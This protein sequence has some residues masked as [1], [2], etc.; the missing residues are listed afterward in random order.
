[1]NLSATKQSSAD[2]NRQNAMIGDQDIS[3]FCIDESTIEQ[4]LRCSLQVSQCNFKQQGSIK[5]NMNKLL[6]QSKQFHRADNAR[7]DFKISQTSSNNVNNLKKNGIYQ[8][9]MDYKNKFTIFENKGE[10]NHLDHSIV[11]QKNK[12]LLEEEEN[13]IKLVSEHLIQS[14]QYLQKRQNQQQSAFLETEGEDVPDENIAIHTIKSDIIG[15]NLLSQKNETTDMEKVKYLEQN[16]TQLVWLQQCRKENERKKQ[17]SQQKDSLDDSDSD[18]D[19]ETPQIFQKVIY[20][21]GSSSETPILARNLGKRKQSNLE[22]SKT[23]SQMINSFSDDYSS[24][25]LEE[26]E[27]SQEMNIQKQQ[28]E[29]SNQMQKNRKL[30]QNQEDQL[31]KD[32]ETM[33]QHM[34]ANGLINSIELQKD[35]VLQSQRLTESQQFNRSQKKFLT[36]SNVQINANQQDQESSY[37]QNISRSIKKQYTAVKPTS[38]QSKLGIHSENNQQIKQSQELSPPFDLLQP[39]ERNSFLIPPQMIDNNIL[40]GSTMD[41]TYDLQQNIQQMKQ[42]NPFEDKQMNQKFNNLMQNSIM[43]NQKKKSILSTQSHNQNHF[44]GK[45]NDQHC[46]GVRFDQNVEFFDSNLDLLKKH[47][48]QSM[49]QSLI[50]ES[51]GGPSL[52]HP[53]GM[54]SQSQNNKVQQNSHN[55]Q[56]TPSIIEQRSSEIKNQHIIQEGWLLKKSTNKMLNTYQKRYFILTSEKLFYSKDPTFKKIKGCINIKYLTC[57]VSLNKTNP[58]KLHL[59]ITE[60]KKLLKLK[61]IVPGDIS[62]WQKNLQQVISYYYNQEK[63]MM[64]Q[65]LQT[66]NN[67][68]RDVI[69]ESDLETI[70]ET[71]DIII[72][73]DSEKSKNLSICN[74]LEM[75]MLIKFNNN[76]LRVFY[77]DKNNSINL[78]HWERFILE[79][80]IYNSLIFRK[81]QMSERNQILPYIYESVRQHLNDN[82]KKKLKDTLSDSQEDSKLLPSIQRNS[83]LIASIYQKANLIKHQKNINKYTT[84]SFC[85]KKR[86]KLLNDAKLS[87]EI[88]VVLKRHIFFASDNSDLE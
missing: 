6:F 5:Q 56:L 75:G 3:V 58:K 28:S 7:T 64:A 86:L 63:V 70:A 80:D 38:A 77:V 22:E 37:S 54:R 30:K 46:Y 25:S 4:S 55:M 32:I 12:D 8:T 24:D 84:D 51:K 73:H 31:Y 11:I 13:L 33:K 17:N 59:K 65:D 18:T 35:Q 52:P 69:T 10:I 21:K 79:N 66:K 45:K 78:C 23:T 49:N 87:N 9:S 61:E 2:A 57:F 48:D 40:S 72:F 71:G 81:L 20:K 60:M 85:Q 39:V 74:Q 27:N 1:M 50:P 83:Q 44:S 14:I 41:E 36:T 19:L 82:Y 88:T 62:K 16:F 43:I 53:S 42:L 67:Y 76:D 47:H 34:H 29:G 15:P 26:N 68:K